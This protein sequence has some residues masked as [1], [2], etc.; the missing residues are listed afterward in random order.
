LQHIP[1][2][3]TAPHSGELLKFDGTH[4]TPADLSGDIEADPTL[5]TDEY[6]VVGLRGHPIN[7]TIEPQ[8]DDVLTFINNEW[9]PHQPETPDLPNLGG[10]VTG[11]PTE[12]TVERI[13][14]VTV[15]PTLPT[16]AG[17]VLTFM[18]GKWTP[19]TP[20]AVTVP[21]L[22]GDVSGNITSNEVVG[23]VSVP[24]D[25]SQ[26]LQPGQTLVYQEDPT[27]PQPKRW[28][29]GNPSTSGNFVEHP[30]GL[31]RYSIEAAGIVRA[32][33]TV[34]QPEWEPVYNGL[35]VRAI[36]VSTLLVFFTTYS[37]PSDPNIKPTDPRHQY[38]VKAMPVYDS[39][40]WE[41]L[42][43]QQPVVNFLRYA[44]PTKDK[45]NGILLHVTDGGLPLAQNILTKLSF[46]IEVSRYESTVPK[47]GKPQLVNLNTATVNELRA[48]PRVGPA[49]AEQIVKTR[50]QL[51][52]FATLSDVLKVPGIGEQLLG[53]ITPFIKLT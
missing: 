34:A 50:K 29:P 40:D 15:D 51:K 20:D 1:I 3:P 9:T 5:S 44:D 4:W 17:Q 21:D 49:L 16:T 6:R 13:R 47:P 42:K 11:P 25:L 39:G 46:V 35:K 18:G 48:L 30:I 37:W 8:P 43:N 32:D 38:I 52:G 26:G 19:H 41:G 14:G 23:I 45:L 28:A 53:H 31:P 12:N 10:D 33:G 7:K 22:K 36:D 27:N 24:I 2:D